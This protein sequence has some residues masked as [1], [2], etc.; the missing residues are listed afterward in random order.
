M[1]SGYAIGELRLLQT[2]NP[3]VPV[4]H[5][6]LTRSCRAHG[7]MLTLA[8]RESAMKA[9]VGNRVA[10]LVVA[11]CIV[12]AWAASHKVRADRVVKLVMIGDSLTEGKGVPETDRIPIQLEFAL[13]AKGQSV[14][15]T[16]AGV[17]G[18]ATKR[19]LARLNRVVTDDTDAVILEL[20]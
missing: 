7:G 16:N 8:T 12:L 6:S 1:G 2:D 15:V 11:L 3:F 13:K 14:A 17:G 18:D 20:G 10:V 19:G 9:E 4:S 5:R